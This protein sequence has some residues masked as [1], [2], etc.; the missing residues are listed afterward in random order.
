MGYLLAIL[1]AFL[2]VGW[3]LRNLDRRKNVVFR[4]GEEIPTPITT[5]DEVLYEPTTP[6]PLEARVMNTA[7][8]RGD[9]HNQPRIDGPEELDYEQLLRRIQLQT[10]QALSYR[11]SLQGE[12]IQL[13]TQRI[14][15]LESLLPPDLKP[16]A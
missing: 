10:I 13:L 14:E 6:T 9:W 16:N 11:I 8:A 4:P 2:L 7:K 5:H 12:T 1:V 3:V 15:H